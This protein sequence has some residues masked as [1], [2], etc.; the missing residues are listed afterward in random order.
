MQASTAKIAGTPVLP[1][2]VITKSPFFIGLLN[3]VLLQLRES[4]SGVIF[5]K[6]A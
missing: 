4:N 3:L 5:T 2:T 1:L 6:S